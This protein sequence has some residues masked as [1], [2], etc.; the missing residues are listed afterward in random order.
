MLEMLNN[1][2][3]DVVVGIEL[4]ARQRAVFISLPCKILDAWRWA[5]LL[6]KLLKSAT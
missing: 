6:P 5:V 3:A 2:R 4:N 1:G